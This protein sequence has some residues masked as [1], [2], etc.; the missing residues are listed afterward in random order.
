MKRLTFLSL[1][2]ALAL[3]LTSCGEAAHGTSFQPDFT[4]AEYTSN[5]MLAAE[6]GYYMTFNSHTFYLEGETL[7]STIFCADPAC[8]H[9]FG[10][11]GGNICLSRIISH[12]GLQC[13]NGEIIFKELRLDWD[14]PDPEPFVLYGVK[15]DGTGLRI[16]QDLWNIETDPWPDTQIGSNYEYPFAIIDDTI[17]F[18]PRSHMVCVGK[19]GGKIEDAKVLFSYNSGNPNINAASAHWM[20]WADGGYFYYCGVNY[21]DAV[22][23]GRPSFLVYRYDPRTEE[24]TLVWRADEMTDTYTLDGFYIKDGIFNYHI[25]EH[26]IEHN[27]SGVWS[28]DLSTGETVKLSEGTGAQYGEFDTD[29]IYL[30]HYDTLTIDVL[31]RSTGDDV[32]ELDLGAA[33]EA[34]GYEVTPWS[35]GVWPSFEWLGADERWLFIS[36][37]IGNY[38][39]PGNYADILWAIA[40]DEFGDNNFRKTII[41][42]MEDYY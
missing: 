39:E 40:K 23:T 5:A 10:S 4:H 6:G 26:E 27:E 7:E 24:N 15:T 33:A 38:R 22:V 32:A 9:K 8:E 19:L 18:C 16:I 3:L 1:I 31:N 25:A 11:N 13:Y 34:Q 20:I 29:F 12:M 28:C 17:M 21:P 14:S 42:D 37:G 2:L 30:L 41:Y 35:G 36:C